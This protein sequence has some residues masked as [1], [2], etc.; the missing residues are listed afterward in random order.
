EVNSEHAERSVATVHCSPFT[1]SPTTRLYKTGDRA[2]YRPDGNIE[3][4]G[5]LDE[6]VKVRGFRVEL[7]EI[8]AALRRHPGI[9]ESAVQ[10][11]GEASGKRLVA[12]VVP[13]DQP[14]AP[15]VLRAFLIE[16]LPDYMIPSAFVALEALPL[17]P[18]GKVNRRALPVPDLNQP[19]ANYVA[20][21]AP[22]EELLANIWAQLLQVE[23]V[24]R[25]DNF[26]ELGG[27][28]LLATQLMSR[29]RSVFQVE[30]P[31]R[32]LFESPTVA[33]LAEQIDSAQRTSVPPIT[34]APRDGPSA[35]S[36]QALPLSFAQQRLWVIDQ[37]EPGASLYNL[38]DV[39]H[40]KGA[41][42]TAALERSLNEIIRRHEI[43]RTTFITVDG[44]P[45]QII[46]PE[47]ALPL[48]VTRTRSP[49]PVPA[50]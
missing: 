3:Y 17:T 18:S 39:L 37:L 42:D 31:L 50:G 25:H 29:V 23:R 41:L 43:L 49:S 45:E 21:R 38:P 22:N 8:E 27:H 48:P 26:F 35:S 12:Y 40:L 6:Q 30:L 7:G 32:A 24:S 33:G 13:A 5:R 47:L 4:L 34:P 14:P 1:D 16:K 15:E 2:R 28:S 19:A 20:P 44:Q 11:L 10:A 36:G 9:R 46:T